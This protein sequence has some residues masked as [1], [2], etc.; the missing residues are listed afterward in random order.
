[1]ITITQ[2]S[3]NEISMRCNYAYRKRCHDIEGARF[4]YDKKAWIAPLSS[5]P[6]ILSDFSGELYFKTP[7]WKLQGQAQPEEEKNTYL[8]PEPVI[9]ELTLKPYKYQENGIKFMIDRLN[10][11]GFVLNG[12]Q[13]GL[14][15]TIQSIGAIKW[16]TE[17][18]GARKILIICKKSIK[19][20]WASEIK[21][22]ANWDKPIFITGS[23]KK[24]RVAAY[25][26]ILEEP[27]GVLITNYH[28]F[29][30]DFEEINKVNYDLCIIDEA[31]CI[32]S[33]SGKMN[34]LIGKT[35]Q[36][37]RTILLT[38]TPIMSRP[39]D[40]WGIVHMVSPKYFG[41]YRSFKEKY[42]VTEFGIYGEQIIGA[43]NLD[44]L[45]DKIKYFT[46]MR[47]ADE[48]ALDLPK[49][50]PSK[51]IRCQMDKVQVKM[52]E[53]VKTKKDKQDQRKKELLDTYGLTEKTRE[54]IEKINEMSK[55]Y[56]ATLQFIAD[57]PAVFSQFCQRLT[58]FLS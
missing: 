13:V 7:L 6:Q 32:K 11:V 46:I 2:I 38:G 14:G 23:T 39:D 16:F 43:R 55:M 20:Q 3:E 57:D 17:N 45:Q 37:K 18:R 9:P 30:N 10:N 56:I 48:V 21:K 41:T 35:V 8:G 31:H 49:R 29:L 19:T 4:D 25:D 53:I 50:R 52:Q 1:M 47:S 34:K 5:L 15:K 12:D 58:L 44:E 22:I 27:E 51:K 28:N 54:E 36:G 33:R 24:K 40:I 26:G 42:I